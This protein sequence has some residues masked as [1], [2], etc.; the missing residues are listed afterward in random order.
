MTPVK[1]KIEK[2]A[3]K[4][5]FGIK[6]KYWPYKFIAIYDLRRMFYELIYNEEISPYLEEKREKN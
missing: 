2:N 3:D 6:A 5:K 1:Q 4:F